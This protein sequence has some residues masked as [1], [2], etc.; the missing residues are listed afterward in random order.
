MPFM[1]MFGGFNI[2][3]SIIDRWTSQKTS[4]DIKKYHWPIDINEIYRTLHPTAIVG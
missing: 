2:P 3:L 1:V 4:K